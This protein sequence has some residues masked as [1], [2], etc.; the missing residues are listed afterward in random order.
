M[1]RLWTGIL[2]LPHGTPLWLVNENIL[3]LLPG[4]IIEWGVYKSR[5]TSVQPEETHCPLALPWNSFSQKS[6]EVTMLI[7]KRCMYLLQ[8]AAV[9]SMYVCAHRNHHISLPGDIS[10]RSLSSHPDIWLVHWTVEWN[11]KNSSV[12]Q[13]RAPRTMMHRLKCAALESSC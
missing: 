4:I 12:G 9:I 13:Q 11:I 8:F 6:S 2:P 7:Y 5:R 3:C 10:I 1:G